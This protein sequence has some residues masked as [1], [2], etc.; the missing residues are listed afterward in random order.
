[1]QKVCLVLEG[2][3]NRGVYT[4]GV[5]DAF[6]DNNIDIRDIYGVSAGALNAISYLSKQKGRSLRISKDHFR[7]ENCMNYKHVLKGKSIVNLDYLFDDVSNNID[8]LDFDEFNKNNRFVV[9][10]TNVETG[11]P[12]YKVV[13]DYNKDL[14]YIKASASLPIFSKIVEVDSLKLLDGGISDSIPIIKA[15]EDGYDKA[16]V[17]L[18]RDRDFVSQPYKF[19]AAYKAKYL[20]YPNFVKAIGNRYNNYNVTR[21]LIFNY[22]NEEKVIVIAPSVP[23]TIKRLEKD[24]SKIDEAYNLGYQDALKYIDQIKNIMGGKK[25]EKG[26]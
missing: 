20:K 6:L 21:D 8:P 16:I 18:T 22:E 24:E 26:R 19:M 25:N 10:A 3:G 7:S 17:I 14:A 11:R 1:M 5:L 13:E 9:V 15:I 12:V 4:A 2:G 23:L